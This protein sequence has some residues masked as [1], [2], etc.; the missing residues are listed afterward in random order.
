MRDYVAELDNRGQEALNRIA[1]LQHPRVIST[2]V[3]K[4]M[5]G[6]TQTIQVEGWREGAYVTVT[7]NSFKA[8]GGDE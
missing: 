4:D 7:I 2:E 3:V 8:A 5:T 1:R 6:T